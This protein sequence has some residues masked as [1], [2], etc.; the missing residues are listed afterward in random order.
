MPA[1]FNNIQHFKGNTAAPLSTTKRLRLMA[2]YLDPKTPRFLDCGCGIGGYVSALVEDLKMDA[3]GIEYDA[4]T[5]E[6]TQ[7]NPVLKNR[8]TQGDLQAIKSESNQWDYAMLNEVLEH[9]GDERKVLREVQRV[10]KPGGLLFIFSPNRWFPFE[11]HC[12]NLKNS[13]HQIPH[14]IPLIPYIPVKLGEKYLFYWGRNYWQ[15]EL[16]DLAINSGF[17]IVERDYIWQTFENI[18]GSQ[19]RWMT[20]IKPAFK[21]ASQTL[22]K[23]P[24]L[25]RFGVS[26]VLVCRKEKSSASV[27]S[28]TQVKKVV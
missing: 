6:Q 4:R 22:E 5:V 11:T 26:Q 7:L 20:A 25:R 12:V 13:E 1:T 18:S 27:N 19:P 21:F 15:K 3:H 10:L 14:W 16:A 8:I 17:A 23:T 2:K 28:E 9:V 24:F